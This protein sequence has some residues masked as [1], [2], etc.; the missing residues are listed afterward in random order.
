MSKVQYINQ[1]DPYI[2]CQLNDRKSIQWPNFLNTAAPST[3]PIP[4]MYFS[5]QQNQTASKTVERQN[6]IFD[7]VS[8]FAHSIQIRTV[9]SQCLL[10][11]LLNWF[12]LFFGPFGLGQSEMTIRSISVQT[13]Q[14]RS[15]CTKANNQ[16]S[17]YCLIYIM[18]YYLQLYI[19]VICMA[20]S[21]FLF[22]IERY[23]PFLSAASH[24]R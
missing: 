13:S 10:S 4:Y 17:Y 9:S 24:C 3:H 1:K 2:S 8:L 6:K 16:L 12:K 14:K 5:L 7:Y 20:A 21:F 18:C 23:S 19:F 11:A 22:K 15:K